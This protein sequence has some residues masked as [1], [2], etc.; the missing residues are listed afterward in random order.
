MFPKILLGMKISFNANEP[1]IKRNLLREIGMGV[2]AQ[3]P[4]GC[5]GSKAATE[6]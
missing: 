2:D 4:L 6:A 3:E 1:L 5:Q